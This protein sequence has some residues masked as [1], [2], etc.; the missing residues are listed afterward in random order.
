MQI[1][2]TR[3]FPGAGVTSLQILESNTKRELK[4]KNLTD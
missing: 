1:K 4:W 3:S 2:C